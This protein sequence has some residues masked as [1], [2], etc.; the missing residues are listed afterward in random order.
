MLHRMHIVLS[1][2]NIKNSSE[3]FRLVG[4]ETRLD[5]MLLEIRWTRRHTSTTEFHPSRGERY[6]RT[7]T[8]VMPNAHR[9]IGC[10]HQEP[11]RSLSPRQVWK[12]LDGMAVTVMKRSSF[13]THM[14][15]CAA[16]DRIRDNA[17]VVVK[18]NM[19]QD[20]EDKREKVTYDGYW[21]ICPKG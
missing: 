3:A 16:N 6:L 18:N 20:D 19:T 14:I 7:C 15:K 4:Y 9:A 17:Q 12:Q 1:R 13:P 5:E 8:D 10:Q 21:R 2:S 11:I